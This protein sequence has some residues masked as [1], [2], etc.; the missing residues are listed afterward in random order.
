TSL[1]GQWWEHQAHD[2]PVV[3]RV[4]PEIAHL[5]RLLDRLHRSLVVRRDD[6]HARLGDADARDLLQRDL[7]AV[8]VDLELLD[9]AGGRAAGADPTELL[10]PVRDRLTHLVATLVERERTEVVAAVPHRA[11]AVSELT[12]VPIGSPSSA[13]WMFPGALTSNTMIGS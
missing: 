7:G 12:N 3:R 6:E 9:E 11:S 4:D 10:L 5:D 13:R 8:R 2:L 1:L